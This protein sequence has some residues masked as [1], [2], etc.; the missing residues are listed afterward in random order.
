MQL[1]EQT[2]KLRQL[3]A[4]LPQRRRRMWKYVSPERR[5]RGLFVLALLL[6]LLYAGWFF[7]NDNFIRREAIKALEKLTAGDVDVHSAEFSLF[8]GISLYKVQVRLRDSSSPRP[9]FSARRVV[10]KHN[11]LSLFLKG[12]LEITEIHCIGP[13]LNIEYDKLAGVSNAERLFRQISQSHS[14]SD[15]GPGPLPSVYLIDGIL[16][17]IV[18]DGQR[19]ETLGGDPAR[20]RWKCSLIPVSSHDIKVTLKREPGPAAKPAKPSKPAKPT[21]KPAEVRDILWARLELDT[22]TGTIRTLEGAATEE[23]FHLLPPKYQEWIDRYSPKGEFRMLEGKNTNPQQGMYEIELED[24]S[25]KLPPEE[26]GLSLANVEGRLLFNRSGVRMEKIS[27]RLVEAGRA[28]FSLN[29]TYQ[30]Y[31]KE[32]PFSL[33]V[34]ITDLR[35]P[36]RATGNLAKIVDSLRKRF[37]PRGSANVSLHYQRDASGQASGAG[38]LTLN[39]VSM[40]ADFF[41]LPMSNVSG[42]VKF[43]PSG[44]GSLDL[45]AQRGLRRFRVTGTV[46]KGAGYQRYDLNVDGQNVS[47]DQALYQALPKDR[48]RKVWD[49]TSPAGRVNGRFRMVDPGKEAKNIYELDIY[50]KGDARMS[51]KWFPYPLGNLFGEVHYRLGRVTIPEILSQAG[52]ALCKIKGTI[53][54]ADKSSPGAQL[55]I[56]AARVPLD[57]TL[58]QALAGQARKLFDAL[59]PSGMLGRVSATINRSSKTGKVDYKI[60]ASLR[61]VAF[62]YEKFPYQVSDAAGELQ[63]TPRSVEIKNLRGKHSQ[64]DISV[65]GKIILTQPELRF[66][67]TCRGENVQLGREFIDALPAKLREVWQSL[68]PAGQ[69]DMSVEL[70]T[71][72]DSGEMAYRLVVDAKAP[73]VTIRFKD[74]PYTFQGVTGRLEASPGRVVLSDAQLLHDKMSAKLSGEVRISKARDEAT[75]KI[76]AKEIPF[77]E[78]FLAAL[79]AEILPLSKWFKPS[80]RCNAEIEKLTFRREKPATPA[81]GKATQARPATVSWSIDGALGF[82]DVLLDIGFGPRKLTGTIDGKAAV[83]PAGGLSVDAD[84]ALTRLELRKHLISAI[85]GRLIKGPASKVFRLNNIVARA[86]GGRL[87]GDATIH[88]SEPVKYRLQASVENI[89]I[90]KLF[91]AGKKPGQAPDKKKMPINGRLAGQIFLE[92]TGGKTPTRQAVGELEISRG[93]MYKMPVILGLL[94]VIYLSVPGDSAFNSGFVQYHLK[95]DTLLLREIYLTGEP[96][97]GVS[98]GISVLGSG[99]MNMKT[100]QLNLTFLT[101]PPGKLPRLDN[102]V[103]EL[104]QAL[105]KELVEIRVTG[106]LDKPVMTTHHLRSL[107]TIIRRILAPS[108]KQ[109]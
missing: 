78:E 27:G 96:E 106:T 44:M 55:A 31:G 7:T 97:H 91:H 66:D 105:S 63:I 81:P 99:R 1:V 61:D 109:Q 41:P 60:D 42:L 73:G 34:K 54:R 64:A 52:G 102:I 108:I 83:S 30:G 6:T 72:E 8:E 90:E 103:T 98:K 85:Q 69:A 80:G 25:L 76:S 107:E 65:D 75:L 26:G 71:P 100:D 48:H 16:R 17:P 28:A 33:D 82:R 67:L 88:L 39:N 101:G 93:H 50:M 18:K 104:L 12:Q 58:R 92:A 29:G 68:A 49:M 35:L 74:F 11:P 53:D 51:C 87:A 62:K 86:H 45:K 13:E 9:F 21:A 77:D 70:K 3:S 84:I 10:L 19:Y 79:P 14:L 89:D 94:N 5:R 95:N 15:T 43:T 59:S 24:F 46:E 40:V 23:L 22:A 38:E 20:W 32:S 37:Q 36:K 57:K 4:R 47:L 56:T 2:K